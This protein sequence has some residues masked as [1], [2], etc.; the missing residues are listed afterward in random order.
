VVG[1]ALP[2]RLVVYVDLLVALLLALVVAEA[3]GTRRPAA[4]RALAGGLLA[5]TV[6]TLL[7]RL[8]FPSTAVGVPAFFRGDGVASLPAGSVALVAPFAHDG[9]SDPAML[10]QAESEMR[11]RMPEGYFVGVR[12]NGVRSDGPHLS[13][14][15]S[16]MIAIQS[17]HAAP[18]LTPRL[19][20]QVM[21]EL[22]RWE[23]RTVLVGPMAHEQRMTT[24]VSALLGRPPTR[25]GGVLVWRLPQG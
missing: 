17:G 1:A 3:L 20:T 25:V 16:A 15:G 11:F 8:P 10:W 22:C 21:D 4:Q 23:V 5:L 24:F 9:P 13:A 2:V 19:R 14:T 12:G 18:A 6:V 7:P